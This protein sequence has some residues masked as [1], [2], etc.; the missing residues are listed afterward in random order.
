MRL[1]LCNQRSILQLEPI[2]YLRSGTK[3]RD[4]CLKSRNSGTHS[5][6]L[7]AN[8]AEIGERCDVEKIVRPRRSLQLRN[9]PPKPLRLSARGIE[10]A[11]QSR[12][13]R[14]ETAHGRGGI[15]EA[16]RREG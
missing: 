6:A 2:R 3:G 13:L 1:S 10:V 16:E 4:F 12:V 7:L 11:P 8:T 9:A 5:I 15:P 14:L